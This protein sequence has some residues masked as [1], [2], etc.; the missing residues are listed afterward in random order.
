MPERAPV[1]PGQESVWD[2]PRPPVAGPCA[3]RV[4][5]VHDGLTVADTAAAYKVCETSWW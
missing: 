3:A 2:Y 4:R 1:G 5:V